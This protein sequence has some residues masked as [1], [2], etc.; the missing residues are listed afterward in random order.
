MG[1][2]KEA[3]MGEAHSNNPKDLWDVL[4]VVGQLLIGIAGLLFTWL[5]NSHL[6]AVQVAEKSERQSIQGRQLTLQRLSTAHDFFDALAGTD[7]CRRETALQL[8]TAAGD[9]PLAEWIGRTTPTT[10]RAVKDVCAPGRVANGA[11]PN[12]QSVRGWVY[13][14]EFHSGLWKSQY[15]DFDE[16]APPKSLLNQTF[17]VRNQTGALNVRTSIPTNGATFPSLVDVLQPGERVKVIGVGPGSQPDY[18]WAQVQ[19][20]PP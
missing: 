13:A 10:G 4:G 12:G 9:Q 15:L 18:F 19:R 2:A 20:S 6:T 17:T 1:E 5:Y 14:G 16:H 11:T 3:V 7:D 8:I